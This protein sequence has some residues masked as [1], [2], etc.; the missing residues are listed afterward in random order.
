MRETDTRV[1]TLAVS[2]TQEKEDREILPPPCSAVLL[3][4]VGPPQ[5]NRPTAAVSIF[6][7]SPSP[8]LSFFLKA[9]LP[10]TI[11]GSPHVKHGRGFWPTS[12]LRSSGDPAP[13][14]VCWGVTHVLSQD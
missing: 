4:V 3:T 13:P 6:M 14:G 2:Q 8:R 9:W 10:F 1:M 11:F 7:L 12:V 5:W